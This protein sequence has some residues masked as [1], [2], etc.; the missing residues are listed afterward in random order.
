[1]RSRYSAYALGNVDYLLET[2]VS[3]DRAGVERFAREARFTGLEVLEAVDDVVEFLATFQVG[4]ERHRL[5]ER[6]RF[7]LREGRWIYV[8]GTTPRSGPVRRETGPG[9]NDPCPCGSGK[10]FKKCCG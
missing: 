10:K 8:D 6:S 9:R 3:Q 4:S 5:H 2:Q 1:M 7:E